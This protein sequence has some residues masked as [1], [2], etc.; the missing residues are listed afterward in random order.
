MEDDYAAHEGGGS[1][2]NLTSYMEDDC[3]VN[4]DNNAC[5]HLNWQGG[6]QGEDAKEPTGKGRLVISSEHYKKNNHGLFVIF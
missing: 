1:R 2:F 3:T 6:G 4:R 5:I